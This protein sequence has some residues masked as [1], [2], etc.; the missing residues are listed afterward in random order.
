[1]TNDETRMANPTRFRVPFVIRV[2]SFF[3]HSCFAIRHSSLKDI[4]SFVRLRRLG[5][6]AFAWFSSMPQYGKK[7]PRTL[8]AASLDTK[9]V[10]APVMTKIISIHSYRGGTGKSNT[11][12]NLATATA[13]HGKRVGIIDTDIQSPGIH[14]IFKLDEK[15]INRS[16]NDYLWG[17]CAIADTAYQ[18]PIPEVQ[19]KGGALFLTPSST[20]AG[21]IAKVLKEGYDVDILND[22]LDALGAA[23]EL[24]YLFIDT[25]PGLNEETLLSIAISDFF[26]LIL[27]PDQQDFQGTAVTVEVA[28][29]LNVQNMYLI[30]NKVHSSIDTAQ[31]RKLVENTYHTSVAG[32]FPL[33]EEMFLLGS[34]GVFILDYPH[35]PWTKELLKVASLLRE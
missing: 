3:R 1:M 32:V 14:V 7:K 26:L 18:I 5:G 16:L 20:K 13:L 17:N 28:R 21:E 25:H 10:A 27:R 34:R 8:A 29:K 6:G 22:G 12:A 11:T 35:H 30:I 23:L 19:E 24:D 33:T 9:E 4:I 2:S 31:L 15:K